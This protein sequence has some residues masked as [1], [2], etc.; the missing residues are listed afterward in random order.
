MEL[1]D[2]LNR[3]VFGVE[4]RDFGCCNGVVLVWN[5]CVELRGTPWRSFQMLKISIFIF[6]K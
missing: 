6:K 2:V 4:V 1:K 3:G 5:R